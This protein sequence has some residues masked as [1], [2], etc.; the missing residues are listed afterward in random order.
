[1][2]TR[3]LIINGKDTN[4]EIDKIV[5]YRRT[6]AQLQTS[7][8]HLSW[9]SAD[10]KEQ[11][12]VERK[13]AETKLILDEYGG[14]GANAV[15][16]ILRNLAPTLTVLDISL[17]TYIAHTMSHTI[18]L[19]HLMDF[20]TRCAFPLRCDDVPVLEPTHSLRYLHVVDTMDEW[21]LA[22]QWF[23]GDGISHFAPSL[24]HLRLSQ[25]E[26]D[27]SVI[28]HLECALGL[29]VPHPTSRI[30][31]LPSTI[32]LI[33]IKP[34]VAPP[35]SDEE[36]PCCDETAGYRHLLKHARR[37][38]NKDPRVLLLEADT[39]RPAEDEYFPEWMDKV[40]GAACRWET[41]NVDPA[42]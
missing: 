34:A 19:P 32:E 9:L 26:Q 36:C 15:V 20:T 17:N 11:E 13:L 1:L 33:L 21:N 24:T 38:R 29:H 37:L 41:S 23:K 28:T 10:T 2:N 22:A 7:I 35:P 8:L 3:Y 6:L 25:L 40:N 5:E 12:T 39:A 42:R 4:A 27:E 16:T 18:H 30:T 14:E 31:Q